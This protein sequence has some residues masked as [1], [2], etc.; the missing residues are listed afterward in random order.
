MTTYINPT[1]YHPT[2]REQRI[3]RAFDLSVK[4]KT[5]PAENQ[6]VF[7]EVM[8]LYLEKEM[9]QAAGDREERGILNSY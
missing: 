6:P 9:D 4:R 3:K 1:I 2:H 5:I 8:D 7:E